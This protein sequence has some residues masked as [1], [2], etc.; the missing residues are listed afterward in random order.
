MCA[1]G[2]VCM[3]VCIWLCVHES[4][5]IWLCLHECLCAFG[6]VVHACCSTKFKHETSMKFPVSVQPI[7]TSDLKCK[8]TES[9]LDDCPRAA[10]PSA[11]CDYTAPRAGV[12][13]YNDTGG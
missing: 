7:L 13:C 5:C 12:L 2:C 3:S 9:Q 6:C 10:V 11:W 4:V 1:F 8:G